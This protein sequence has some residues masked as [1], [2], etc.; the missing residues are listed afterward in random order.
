MRNQKQ[1][2]P[3]GDVRREIKQRRLAYFVQ[4]LI[5]A[6]NSTGRGIRWSPF[7]S[8]DEV[9]E[10]LALQGF[11]GDPRGVRFYALLEPTTERGWA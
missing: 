3:G 7:L 1:H 11:D 2:D 10:T 9:R 6:G 4:A 8:T 5:D